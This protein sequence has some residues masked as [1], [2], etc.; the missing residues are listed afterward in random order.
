[1]KADIV[2]TTFENGEFRERVVGHA[3]ITLK[4]DLKRR[5][6]EIAAR[7]FRTDFHVRRDGERLFM[8]IAVDRHGDTIHLK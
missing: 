4:T 7:H 5:L 2:L 3:R 8:F 6:Q 1:M